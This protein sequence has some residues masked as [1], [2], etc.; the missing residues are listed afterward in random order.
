MYVN[1]FIEPASKLNCGVALECGEQL[2]QRREAFVEPD[3]GSLRVPARVGGSGGENPALEQD[4]VA[5]VE[6]EEGSRLA[7]VLKAN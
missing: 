3:Q 7:C 2:L 4:V 5:R 1:I 6:P